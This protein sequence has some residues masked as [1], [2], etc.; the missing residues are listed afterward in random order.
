MSRSNSNGSFLNFDFVSELSFLEEGQFHLFDTIV[1]IQFWIV[2]Q[3]L[4]A[5]FSVDGKGDSEQALRSRP[6][7]LEFGALH[8]ISMLH[9]SISDSDLYKMCRLGTNDLHSIFSF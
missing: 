4:S 5:P 2:E 8:L 1:N 6:L 3:R 7:E 9:P